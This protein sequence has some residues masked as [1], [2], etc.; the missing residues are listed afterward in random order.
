MISYNIHTGVKQIKSKVTIALIAMGLVLGGGGL[1]MVNLGAAHASIPTVPSGWELTA[2]SGIVF[3]CGGSDYAHTLNTVSQD[4]NGDLTGT[5]TYDVNTGY[6]WDLV[7]NIDGDNI[8][9]TITYTGIAAGTVYNSGGVIAADGSIDGT[10]DNNCQYFSMSSD[11]AT[12]FEGNHG[13][14]VKSQDDKK[15]AAQSRIGMPVQSKGH[16]R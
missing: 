16:T 9:F 5:G 10:V 7:G 13:Q 2:Q 6:T 14:Y 1:A 4:V 11:A 8:I 3:N 15:G 12:R